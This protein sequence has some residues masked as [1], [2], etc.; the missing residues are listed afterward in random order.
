MPSLVCL[1]KHYTLAG[2]YKC[3]V[4]V[5]RTTSHE[6]AQRTSEILLL[7]LPLEHRIR[8]FSLLCNILHIIYRMIHAHQG[9]F[10]YDLEAELPRARASLHDGCQNTGV[11]KAIV[12]FCCVN[13]DTVFDWRH[14]G[15]VP[16][17]DLNTV[18]A[19][20]SPFQFLGLKELTF[21][22]GLGDFDIK[23]YRTAPKPDG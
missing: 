19:L 17:K 21:R 6:L 22:Y 15:R 3:Y 5:V 10:T 13:S 14:R 7:L 20:K 8:I 16:I 9:H 18:R 2:R 12:S 1:C 11:N 23:L 4:L